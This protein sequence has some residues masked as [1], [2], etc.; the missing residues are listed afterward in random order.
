M[1][2]HV[3]D[4]KSNPE[5]ATDGGRLVGAV[6][7]D[8]VLDRVLPT[9]WRVRRARATSAPV[10]ESF[11]AERRGSRAACYSCAI[12]VDD[13]LKSRTD[14]SAG[15]RVGVSVAFGACVAVVVGFLGG[16]AL[17]PMMG[18]D[19]SGLFFLGW[20]WLSVWRLDAGET[21]RH[22]VRDDPRKALADVVLLSASVISLVAVGGVLVH[23]S[24]SSGLSKE[25]LVGLGISSVL[26]AWGVVHTVFT[27]RYAHL[28]Y[29]RPVGGVDFNEDAPPRYRDFAYLS[30]TIGMT[31]QVSDTD[32]Q[33]KGIRATALRHALLSYLFGAVIIATTINLVAGLTK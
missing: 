29:A 24:K 22:A 9:G 11:P 15:A 14:A 5:I 20:I 28:Y 17:A 1:S 8:D 30:F 25:V 13:A 27:L 32:L 2:Q 18:W 6:T 26:V 23:A 31:F 19:G 3:A 7:I 10:S 16:G 4:G 33:A 12:T 21:A